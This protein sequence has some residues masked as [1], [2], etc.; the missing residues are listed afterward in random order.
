[1]QGITRGL[2]AGVLALF[3]ASTFGCAPD[4]AKMEQIA[5]RVAK[6]EARAAIQEYAKSFAPVKFGFGGALEKEWSHAQA[7]KTGNMI[8]ISGQQPYDTNLNE[9]GMPKTD[10]ETG[11]NFEQQLTT[12]LEN[13]QK[14]LDNYGATMDD[15]VFLQAF[16]DEKAGKN[17]AQFNNA[18]AVIKKFFPKAQQSMTFISVDNLFGPEQLI[19]ANAIAVVSK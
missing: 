2:Y 7:V 13:I 3:L 5:R 1:M 16:V 19:E 14:A 15:V 18:A 4:E 6:E 10:L 9:K 8:F 11:R 12:V 17:S